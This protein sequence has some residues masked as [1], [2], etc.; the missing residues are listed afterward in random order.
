MAGKTSRYKVMERKMSYILLADAA[1][2][3]LYLIFAWTGVV[4]LKIITGILAFLLSGG[5]LAFLYLSQELLKKRSLWM[6]TAAAAIALCTLV[7]LVLNY[8]RPNTYK[9]IATESHISTYDAN[10]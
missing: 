9:D 10:V 3:L 2:F 7:S 5:C 6:S 8:P 4:W 1:L